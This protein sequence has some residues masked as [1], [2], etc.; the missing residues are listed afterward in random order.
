MK[1]RLPIAVLSLVCLLGVA[2]IAQAKKA[3]KTTYLVAD[4][5]S[6]QSGATTTD[7]NLKNAWGMAFF[8]GAP[9]W[10]ADNGS[11]VSTLYDGAGTPQP[12]P[13]PLVVK[14]PTPSANTGAAATGLVANTTTGFC[15]PRTTR[16]RNSFS[17]AKTAP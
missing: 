5:V 17:I 15:F 8:P 13:T 14:L 11:G 16:P 4:L 6:N 2:G 7:T 10:I 12:Q 1:V 3:P 9:F